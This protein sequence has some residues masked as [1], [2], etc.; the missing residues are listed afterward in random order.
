M[1]EDNTLSMKQSLLLNQN[2]QEP[3]RNVFYKVLPIILLVSLLGLLWG[4]SDKLKLL[5]E[6]KAVATQVNCDFQ[7]QLK[8]GFDTP[9][10]D[11]QL[12]VDRKIKSLEPFKLSIHS[13]NPKWQRAQISFEGFYDYMGINKFDFAVDSQNN[14]LWHAKASIPICTTDAK[15]WRVL[16]NL[17]ATDSTNSQN[18]AP[19]SSHWFKIKTN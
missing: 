17:F 6:N 11:V 18:Q 12:S 5:L 10:G 16:V 7:Q 19:S 14:H 2:D 4:F 1:D 8:C 13:E 9:L 15:T 3:S